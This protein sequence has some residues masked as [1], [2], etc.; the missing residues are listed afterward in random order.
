MNKFKYIVI[1][2]V[3]FYVSSAYGLTFQNVSHNKMIFNPAKSE[4][5]K[6]GFELDEEVYVTLSMFDARD[7]RIRKVYSTVL[8]DAGQHSLIWD[9]RDQAKR[10]VPP[11]AY[12]YTL[13][14]YSKKGG[15]VEY[16][17]TDFTVGKTE[18]VKD[19]VWDEAQN[20]IRFKLA[21]PS[22]VTL[23]IGLGENGPLLNTLLNWVAR[24]NGEQ[25]VEWDGFDVSGTINLRSHPAREIGVH[26]FPLSTNT[27]LI[28]PF[29]KRIKIIE[30]IPWQ[31]EKRTIKR[32]R[33]KRMFAQHLRS[34]EQRGDFPILLVPMG[35]RIKNND[36][37]FVVSREVIFKLDVPDEYRSKVAAQRFE[38]VFFLDGQFIGESEKGTLPMTWHWNPADI[39]EGVHYITANVRGFEGDFGTNTIKII[40][41][42][43]RTTSGK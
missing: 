30:N 8:L 36:G 29:H 23:R 7:I 41:K 11:G 10:S 31:I 12:H 32:K 38:S 6:I 28:G 14:G 35:K 19:V 17:P 33:K 24:P 9:G 3:F 2:V 5:V 1:S 40:Y 34:A 39:N 37:E 13:T 21:R 43:K 27:I 4:N 16:D 18:W 15:S 42:P 20:Q 26:A 22:R 25:M